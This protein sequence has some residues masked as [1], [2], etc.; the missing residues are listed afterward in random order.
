M[1]KKLLI[2]FSIL[3]VFFNCTFA[4]TNKSISGTV[5]DAITKGTDYLTYAMYAASVVAIISIGFM[6]FHNI[7]DTMLKH[8]TRLV[9]LLSLLTLAFSVPTWFGLC[10]FINF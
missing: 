6:L 10:V 8:V 1:K 9:A 3:S 5:G 2:F 7:Q 4:L